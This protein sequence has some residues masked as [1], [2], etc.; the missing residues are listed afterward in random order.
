MTGLDMGTG[1]MLGQWDPGTGLTAVTVVVPLILS[2]TLH[3]FSYPWSPAVQ[4]QMVLLM[5]PQKANNSL[6]LHPNVYI[7]HL[8]SSHHVGIL[9]SHIT[10]RGVSTV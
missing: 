9:S 10:A 8:T 1:S 6:T 4:K 2:F 5:N 3:S 7:I